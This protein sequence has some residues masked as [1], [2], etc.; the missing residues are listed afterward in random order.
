[1]KRWA[2]RKATQAGNAMSRAG[3]GVRGFFGGAR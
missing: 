3:R 1:L 2:G